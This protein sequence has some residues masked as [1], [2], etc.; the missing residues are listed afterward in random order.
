MKAKK[1]ILA[2]LFLF[3]IMI[4]GCTESTEPEEDVNNVEFGNTMNELDQML[5]SMMS[6]DLTIAMLQMPETDS[7]LFD[8]SIVTQNIW[9]SGF[10]FN[11]FG[12][13]NDSTL[14]QLFTLLTSLN[15]TFTYD[16]QNW[17][18]D[19]VPNNE[20]LLIYPY[21]SLSD[22]ASHTV[23]IRFY[24]MTISNSTFT[25]SNEVY[26]DDI[27]RF[28]MNIE[29][30]GSNLF[31]ILSPQ[32]LDNL[33]VNGEIVDNQ[34]NVYI[35]SASITDTTVEF[36]LGRDGQDELVVVASGSGFLSQS[37]FGEDSFNEDNV[38]S[39]TITY[40][41]VKIVITDF[42]KESG[43]IGDV[44]LRD[45]KIGDVIIIDGEIYVVYNNDTRVKLK[46]LM[47]TLATLESLGFG[48]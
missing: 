31:A 44:F 19:P 27:R 30:N 34:G 35:F 18:Y 1:A 36:R 9:G 6:S 47:T 21:I 40:S 20:L 23:R 41:T 24:D 45:E 42:N 3:V 14:I 5:G 11:A 10:F 22:G 12:P 46:E 16:G 13:Q 2:L 43:D 32:V 29:L 17:S 37:L 4:I 26:I 48:N 28:W 15:G 8:D 25:L 33:Q 38:N 7:L 39:V